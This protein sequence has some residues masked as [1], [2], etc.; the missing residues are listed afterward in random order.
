MSQ[1]NV[2]ASA[3]TPPPVFA[4]PIGQVAQ[5]GAVYIT[6]P[7]LQFL[8]TLWASLVGTGSIEDISVFGASAPPPSPIGAVS[9][10]AN[11][12]FA[13]RSPPGPS[14]QD[15]AG[16]LGFMPSPSR[17]QLDLDPVTWT[18]T[19]QGSSTAGAQTYGTQIGTM[20]YIGPL[21]LALFQIVLTA[22]DGSTAGNLQVGGLPVAG[23]AMPGLTQAGWVASFA[24][25]TL[26]GSGNQVGL[27]VQPGATSMLLQQS[28]SSAAS[29]A[30]PASALS[31]TTAIV[32]GALFFH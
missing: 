3:N 5:G 8:Q 11:A 31:S 26:T 27:E 16:A 21:C 6:I 2:Q 28:A 13:A 19:I 23:A 1:S 14:L 30:I 18:P 17:P 22:K 24:N 9:A 12:G 7:F 4:L 15:I 29:S 10:L 32:G 20:I 25:L